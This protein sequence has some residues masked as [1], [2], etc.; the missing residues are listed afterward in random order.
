MSNIKSGK[1][2][3]AGIGETKFGKVT[4][5]TPL[6]LN[7]EACKK[8]IEDAGLTNKD[9][10]GLFSQQPYFDPTFGISTWIGEYLGL[11]LKISSDLNIGGATPAAMVK[12]AM[13]SIETGMC[14]YALCCYGENAFTGQGQERHGSYNWG[15]EDYYET[16]GA[17][18]PATLYGNIM[19]RHM[20]QYG[21][22][23]EHFGAIALACRNHANLNPDAR[24]YGKPLT[25]EDYLE[26]PYFVE[27]LRL[28]DICLIS[29]GGCACLVTSAERAKDLKS[30]PVYILGL[31]EGHI[32]GHSEFLY[33]APDFTSPGGG[34]SCGQ[35]AYNMAGLT[36]DDI[37]FAEFYD[38]FTST[39]MVQ[40]EDYGFCKKG[41][42]G[43]F[44]E[45]GRIGLGGELPINTHG[46]LLSS[47]HIDG[48]NHITEG[49]KQL[50]REVPDQRQVKDAKIGLITG[51]GG[52]SGTYSCLILGRE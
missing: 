9:V 39:V 2:V 35:Q 51:F 15:L 33:T 14:N 30:S 22:K 31:G 8:A 5:S 19:R 49:V 25:M 18:G 28:T 16:F 20:H 7:L 36:P 23:A 27:P 42:G 50:R 48:F 12:Y 37:D 32:P 38:C 24:M 40:I 11:D 52:L 10:D 4:N 26:T 45:D 34:S 29:D 44:V 46:G 43:S 47:A 13:M 6:S 1:Y 3:I 17:L 21:T 41:E